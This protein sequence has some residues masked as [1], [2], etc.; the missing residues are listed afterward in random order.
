MFLAEYGKA[1]GQ[2]MLIPSEAWSLT[3]YLLGH[4]WPMGFPDSPAALGG[5]LLQ[6]LWPFP[7]PAFLSC[8][9]S[10]PSDLGHLTWDIVQGCS[11][12]SPRCWVLPS[13]GESIWLFSDWSGSRGDGQFCVWSSGM[14]LLSSIWPIILA[15]ASGL[16]A[17]WRFPFSW[18][19][20]SWSDDSLAG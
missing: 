18:C 8:P 2:P 14:L 12:C 16:W 17:N 4:L 5:I 3:G 19:G 6:L 15:V 7:C 20:A 9:L 11:P 10:S 1:L 13:S